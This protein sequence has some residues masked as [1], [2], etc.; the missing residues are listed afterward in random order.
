MRARRS[1]LA[2]VDWTVAAV[3]L[4]SAVFVV[5]VW[6]GCVVAVQDLSVPP[7]TTLTAPQWILGGIAIGVPVAALAAIVTR[8][9]PPQ[10]RR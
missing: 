7:S 2:R 6:S 3:F 9:R 4:G 1:V 10:R 8:A 5:L